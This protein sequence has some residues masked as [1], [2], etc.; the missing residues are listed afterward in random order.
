MA[1]YGLLVHFTDFF[2]AF[3]GLFKGIL[4]TFFGHFTDF[5]VDCMTNYKTKKVQ[6][7][8]DSNHR[9]LAP[10]LFSLLHKL[11]IHIKCIETQ[12][13]QNDYGNK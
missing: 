6:Q 11:T 2:R 13:Q 7:H 10:D 12:N 9:P 4:R 1:F 3:Y 8:Q 5:S